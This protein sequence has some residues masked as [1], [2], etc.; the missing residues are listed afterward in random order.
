[1]NV[2]VTAGGTTAPID[3]V[4][5]IANASTGRFGAAIAEAALGRG[6]TVWHLHAPGALR[7]FDRLARLDLDADLAGE[8]ARL[9]RLRDEW[10]GVR[11]RLRDVP[12]VKGTVPEYSERLEQVFRDHRID[13]V[14]LAMAASDFAPAPVPGKLS[15]DVDA[16]TLRC[17]RL[18]K[19]IRSVRD[20]APE[21]YLVGFKLLSRAPH[22][23]L[24]REAE[25]A[26]VENRADLTVAN[27]LTTLR[28]GRHTVHLVRP[29]HAPE[30]LGPDG[31]VA[32]LLVDRA[33][34]LAAARPRR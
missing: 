3:D 4:R 21:V 20:W 18:P 6:A 31:P 1:M 19:V 27:D 13:V 29:G 26:C 23:E 12:L 25:A 2:V 9:A 10:R 7:P 30:T 16:L 15:S 24:I 22:A 5:S 32:D 8:V 14:F 28:A 33:F 17:R 34:A 11:D